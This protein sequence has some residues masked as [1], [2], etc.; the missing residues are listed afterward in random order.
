MKIGNIEIDKGILLA[1]MED[2]TDL[3]FRVI[4]KRLG[5]DIVYTE[6]VNSEGLVRNT[7]KTKKK[8]LFWEEERPFAIQIYGG[9]PASM[10]GAAQLAESFS[11][12]IIDINCGCWVKDVAMR[13]AGAGLLR[14][15]PKMEKI[16]S[17]VVNAV[18]T[19]VTL[20][21][22]LGWDKSSIRIV[23]VARMCE[24]VGI[25]ALAVH[26]RTRDQGHKGE[27]D[28]SWIP[29]IKEAVSIPIIVNGDIVSPQNVK[30]VFDTTGCDAV[31]IGRGAVLNPWI[32]RQAKQFMATGELLP[33][34]TIE[35]RV[36]LLRE[37]LKLSV[38]FKGERAGVIELRKHYSGFLRGM[39]HISKVRMELMQYTEAEPILEHLTNFL[40]LY[41]PSSEAIAV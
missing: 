25:R 24:A 17:T 38:E 28:Y 22:R 15:L 35:E 34:P 41:S 16:A 40:E 31:M 26:C 4:C 32:F 33:E 23:D 11:P 37:H 14:D 8:M 10:Y 39:P 36:G 12:D 3:P 18:K 1:P 2:V 5:A 9:E 29:K 6:F 30:T 27:V 20:K 13:G 21:T 7:E 19:P